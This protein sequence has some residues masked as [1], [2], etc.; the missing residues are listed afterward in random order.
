MPT[1]SIN[2]VS[3]HYAESGNA[4]APPLVLLH[5]FPLNGAMWGPQVEAFASR[6]R[7]IVPD[8]RGFGQSGETGPFSIEQLADDTHGLIEKLG[9]RKVVLA[10]LSM[11]GYVAFAYAKKYL[12]TL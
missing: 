10:G 4:D 7:V 6:W 11:G 12:A 9:L 2:G 8:F 3:I 5:G 1:A